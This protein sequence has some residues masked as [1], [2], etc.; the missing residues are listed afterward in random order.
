[1]KSARFCAAVDFSPANHA[2]ADDGCQDSAH[3]CESAGCGDGRASAAHLADHLVGAR[4][5]DAR[6][7]SEDVRESFLHDAAGERGAR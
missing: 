6:R 4:S 1:M 5:D 7:A 2:D 3:E